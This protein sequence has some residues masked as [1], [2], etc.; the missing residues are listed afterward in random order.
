[1]RAAAVSSAR[2]GDS[3]LSSYDRACVA[4]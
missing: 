2:S 1:L 4:T 3:A